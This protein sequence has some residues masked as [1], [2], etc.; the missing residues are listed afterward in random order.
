MTQENPLPGN[1]REQ[2]K[3]TVNGFVS[4]VDR[5]IEEWFGARDPVGFRKA[6]LAIAAIGRAISDAVTAVIVKAIVGDSKHQ[7]E[8]SIAARATGAYRHGGTREVGVTLLGG[9]RIRVRAEYLKVNRRAQPGRRRGTG[10]RGRG[11]TGFY[12]ALAV[13]GIVLGVTP[14]LAGEICRQVAD[15]DSVRAGR[16]A[17]DRRGIDLGHKQTL[18]IVNGFAKRAVQQRDGWLAKA[19]L[20]QARSG[21][22]KGKRVVVATDGGRLRERCPTNRGRRRAKTRHR[23]YDAPW[24]EPKLL[25]IY[26]IGKDGKIENEFRPVYDGTLGDCDVIFDMLVGY[27]K[28]LG[29]HEARELI[30]LGD[31][32]KWIWDRAERFVTRVGI[33]AE[34]V[35]QIIDWCHAVAVLHEIADARVSWSTTERERWIKRAKKKLHAGKID[36]L[37]ELI[38]ELAVGRR[39]KDVSEHRDYFARNASRM[40]YASFVKAR[41]PIGSGAIESAVRRVIN[42]RMKSN[43]MFWLEVNAEGMLLLRSYLKADHF[44]ALVDWSISAAVPWRNRRRDSDTFEMPFATGQ[45]AQ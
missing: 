23:R 18:R 6:E 36:D 3:G 8:A 15:S 41:I 45:Q 5:H 7:A 10:R 2:I 1:L 43:G 42:M 33:A 37:L 44:D 38:D 34:R 29:A 30:L 39:A 4:V 24:R 21:L 17:L 14:A 28:A 22:L 32:A 25:T 20:G 40:Q 12:P 31:G 16:A 35:K 11:G 27:L 9:T 13:L 19:R 26:V